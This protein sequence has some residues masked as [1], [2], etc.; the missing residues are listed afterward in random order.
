MKSFVRKAFT[1]RVSKSYANQVLGGNILLTARSGESV[2][3]KDVSV[4][5]SD[6]LTP[7]FL[8]LFLFLTVGVK[9]KTQ[10]KSNLNIKIRHLS[11]F[12]NIC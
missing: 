8:S 9:N 6:T 5:S 1:Q 2:G 12:W 11:S 7:P 10:L 4:F 3:C